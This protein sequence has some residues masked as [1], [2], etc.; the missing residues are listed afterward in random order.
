MISKKH[1]RGRNEKTSEIDGT[2][3][4]ACHDS[5]AFNRLWQLKK[6]DEKQIRDRL[7]AF[8]SACNAGDLDEVL[9]WLDKSSRNTYS[10]MFR[11]GNGIL[12][13]LTGFSINVED[14]L[15]VMLGLSP[16]DFFEMDIQSISLNSE[17]KA[18]VTV[19]I[20]FTDPQTGEKISQD[21]L[22][23]SMI[24][25]KWDWYIDARIDWYSLIEEMS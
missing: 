3:V 17:E 19:S 13:G 1:K 7:D 20:S 18:T 4:S 23:L 9:E 5:G 15:A 2:G 22:M 10:A 25:E 8:E 14:L 21:G 11:I 16:Q 12:G 24:K 6:N